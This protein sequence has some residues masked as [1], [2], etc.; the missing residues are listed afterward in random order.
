MPHAPIG[1][2]GFL[3]FSLA[4]GGGGKSPN[5]GQAGA[6]GGRFCVGILFDKTFLL[7]WGEMTWVLQSESGLLELCG[8]DW[9]KAIGLATAAVM[10]GP[11]LIGVVGC[12]WLV[13]AFAFPTAIDAHV[14]GLGV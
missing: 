11:L 8:G 4:P 5:A 6:G 3:S 14:P 2:F 13:S 7:R 9:G 10:V 1:L 12:L